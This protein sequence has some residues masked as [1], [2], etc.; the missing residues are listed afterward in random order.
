MKFS[1]VCFMHVY[2]NFI[3]YVKIDAVHKNNKSQP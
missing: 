1:T 2:M 3:N